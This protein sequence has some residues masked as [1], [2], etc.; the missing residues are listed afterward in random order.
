MDNNRIKN[1]YTLVEILVGIAIF[2]LLVA[3]PTGLFISSL[4]SQNRILGLREVVDSSSY[5]L[6]Y[7]SR[8]LRM[9]RKDLEGNCVQGGD[10]YNYGFPVGQNTRIIFLN[11]QNICQQFAL[12]DG[13]RLKE[14][15]S[16]DGNKANF[17]QFMS[18]TSQR[19]SVDLLQF[20]IKGEAQAD[21]LQPRVTILLEM[22]KRAVSGFPEVK[23]QTTISQRDLDVHY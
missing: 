8:A 19:L 22:T 9:A 13:Y 15:K 18:L 1:G 11:Y 3:G 10:I 21:N 12:I 17:G 5:V 2:A 6:E 7:M 14:R 16:T 23:A 4:K 20:E